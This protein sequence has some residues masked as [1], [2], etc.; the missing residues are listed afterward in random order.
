MDNPSDSSDDPGGLNP[1]DGIDRA[2]GIGRRHSY[3]SYAAL[4]TRDFLPFSGGLRRPEHLADL[5]LTL[6]AWPVFVMT[7]HETRRSFE[8][9]FLRLQFKNCIPAEDFLG[10]CERPVGDGNLSS[11]QPDAGACRGW[12]KPAAFDHFTGLRCFFGEL[13]HGLH[14][15]LWWRTRSLG[16]FDHHHESHCDNSP[17]YVPVW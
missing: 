3:P 4:H 12:A 11:R 14:Q 1:P 2:M 16:G 8:R 15:F 10:L 17:C 13:V 7:F 9:L 6:P 5:G